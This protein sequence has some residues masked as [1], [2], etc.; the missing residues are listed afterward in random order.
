VATVVA[1][2]APGWHLSG[3]GWRRRQAGAVLR[4]GMDVGGRRGWIAIRGGELHGAGHADT[5][6][7]AMARA[8][9][10]LPAPLRPGSPTPRGRGTAVAEFPGARSAAAGER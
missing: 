3:T 10:A 9:A 2:G 7:E 8:E 1:F 4:V 5:L 6:E